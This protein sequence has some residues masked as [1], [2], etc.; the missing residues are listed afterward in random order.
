MRV[1]FDHYLSGLAYLWTEQYYTSIVIEKEI[2]KYG[3]IENK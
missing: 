2:I 3:S 1:H